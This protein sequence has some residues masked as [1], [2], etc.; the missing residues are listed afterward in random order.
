MPR[1]RPSRII[2]DLSTDAD[3]D[4]AESTYA[5]RLLSDLREVFADAQTLYTATVLDRLHKIEDAPWAN[6][7]GRM[8][9]AGDLARLLKDYRVKPVDVREPGGEA[10]T[11]VE[12]IP[13]LGDD[14]F[15]PL[16]V[17]G[18]GEFG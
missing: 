6:Y 9:T 10:W 18:S 13:W 11:M 16:Y 15:R 17:E 2:S 3:A 12:D 7:F 1:R 14:G 8:L 4:S 5:K